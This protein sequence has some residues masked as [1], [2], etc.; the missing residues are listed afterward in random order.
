MWK[1]SSC[2]IKISFPV[3][4]HL[5]E[6]K[7]NIIVGGSSHAPVRILASAANPNAP[8]TSCQLALSRSELLLCLG[9]AGSSSRVAKP[10]GWCCPFCCRY[11]LLHCLQLRGQGLRRKDRH[12][13]QRSQ[14]AMP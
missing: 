7:A 3:P 10:S 11:H 6:Y 4:L 9:R 14:A 8:S 13:G 5:S 12:H 1:K 2:L